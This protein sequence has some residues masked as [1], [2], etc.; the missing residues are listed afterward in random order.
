MSS[1]KCPN[2]GLVNWS[3]A[4]NCKRCEAPLQQIDAPLQQFDAAAVMP[5]LQVDQPQRVLG[6]LMIIWGVVILGAGL[7][8][9]RVGGSVDP[10]LLGGPV[11][12]IS[13]ILVMRGQP[14]AMRLYFLGLVGMCVWMAVAKSVP[15]AIAGFIFPG[16]VGLMVAKRRFPILA[17]FLIVLSCLA[18]LAP[19]LIAGLLK[20][21]KVA[22]R[23]FRP[24]QGLFAVKMPSEPIARDPIVDHVGSYTT[25]NHPYESLIRGQGSALY[26]VVDFSPALSTEGV[27]YEKILD[28]ELNA[29]VTRTSSTL[30]SKRNTSV[31]GY[32]GLEFE[33]RPPEKLALSSPKCFGKIFMNSDHLYLMG[34]TASETSELMAGKDDF[35]NP[36]F[37]Y[38]SAN[39]QPAR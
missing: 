12:L 33:M 16:L 18:F 24:A 19:F 3:E 26:I 4:T 29:L 20:P 23:D 31:N 5:A 25:T 15:V 34:L 2:C 39:S 9:L 28:A 8:I 36:T 1:E 21:A 38:R 14:A 13:G 35:L 10:V 32:P 11:I 22:W 30:I 6:F 37:A 17:G 27:S 7:F